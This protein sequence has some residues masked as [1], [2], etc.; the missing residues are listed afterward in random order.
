MLHHENVM[1]EPGFPLPDGEALLKESSENHLL[2]PSASLVGRLCHPYLTSSRLIFCEA[3][4]DIPGMREKGVGSVIHEFPLGAIESLRLSPESLEPNLEMDV[5]NSQKELEK[6]FLCFRDEGWHAGAA[7]RLAERDDWAA[8]ISRERL[9]MG[10]PVTTY[11]PE[12]LSLGIPKPAS[13]PS[14]GAPKILAG[15]YEI[16]RPIGSGGM[17]EVFEGKDHALDRPVAVKKMRSDFKLS[18]RDKAL[19][20]QEAKLSA[21]LH[22][23]FI[24]D[25]YAIIEEGD[26][27]FL[28]FEYVEGR[29]LQEQLDDQGHVEE[30]NARPLL[31]GVCEALAF[32][33]SCKVVHRDIKPSNI[34]LTKHGYPKVMDFGISRQI[35]DT[36][37]RLSTTKTDTSGTLPYMAPEQELGR[38]DPRSDVFALGVTVYELLSGE[39]PYIGPNFY[40]Q[41]EKGHFRPLAEVAPGVS[42]EFR[43][44]VERCMRFEAGER[45]QTVTEFAAAIGAAA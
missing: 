13:A 36:A 42:P 9:K 34:M 40:L 10:A 15:K 24:V 12:R 28:I 14:S 17:G 7:V 8:C 35:K 22:H 16:L 38:S 21:A 39:L 26:E 41:K 2:R 5:R 1:P 43:A 23:P 33:H 29:T 4:Y 19:F 37:S 18:G 11:Q 20:M 32:A 27:I 3:Y 31:K 45:F 25:I 30:A 6:V 44:A